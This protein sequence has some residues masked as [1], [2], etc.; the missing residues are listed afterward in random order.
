M[1]KSHDSPAPFSL[2]RVGAHSGARLRGDNSLKT[3]LERCWLGAE[4]LQRCCFLLLELSSHFFG[5]LTQRVATQLSLRPPTRSQVVISQARHHNFLALV[6]SHFHVGV[7]SKPS[8]AIWLLSPISSASSFADWGQRDQGEAAG[9][10]EWTSA[11]Q[12]TLALLAPRCALIS[13][14][15]VSKNALSKWRAWCGELGSAARESRLSSVGRG[16]KMKTNSRLL[17]LLLRGQLLA[18]VSLHNLPHGSDKKKHA[19]SIIFSW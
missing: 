7:R 5:I 6:S 15:E 16:L 13:A 18:G 3:K 19:P 10:V 4:V 8:S 14:R 1:Q 12:R 11:R 2:A 9:P 17:T